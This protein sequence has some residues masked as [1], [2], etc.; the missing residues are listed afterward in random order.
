MKPKTFGAWLKA[1]LKENKILQREMAKQICVSPNT[2]TSWTTNAR[3]PSIR[4]FKW[5]CKFIAIIEDK[6][7][8]EII[9]EALHF[10]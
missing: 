8:A 7:E 6:P 10:F 3:E 2:L 1:K 5:I 9:N 4:N